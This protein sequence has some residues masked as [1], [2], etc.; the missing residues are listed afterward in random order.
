MA[1][2]LFLGLDVGTSGVK[3]ILVAPTG[4]VMAA[5]TTPLARSAPQITTPI[6]A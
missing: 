5:S 2:S 1:Q 3:A 4:E 6:A